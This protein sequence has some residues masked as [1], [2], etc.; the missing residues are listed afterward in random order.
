MYLR[1]TLDREIS[2]FWD[3]G[4]RAIFDFHLDGSP[5]QDAQGRYIKVG[6]MMANTWFHVAIGHTVKATLANASR[7]LI[8]QA[9]RSGIRCRFEYID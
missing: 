6:S 1:M 4:P 9:K 8:A 5:R 2:G 7:W 3:G